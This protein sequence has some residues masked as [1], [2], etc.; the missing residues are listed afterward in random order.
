M[1]ADAGF[2]AEVDQQLLQAANLLRSPSYHAGL[3]VLL[4]DEMHVREDLVFNKH[5]AG[6]IGWLR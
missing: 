5:S 3:A 6:K 1:N 2:S 4:L